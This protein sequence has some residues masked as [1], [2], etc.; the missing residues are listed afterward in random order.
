MRD[1]VHHGGQLL[2]C[3]GMITIKGYV[4]TS[5]LE[6]KEKSVN[7]VHFTAKKREKRK[8]PSGIRTHDLPLTKRMLYQLSY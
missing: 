6:K 3:V 1:M 7:L 8:A 4:D 2:C 5:L